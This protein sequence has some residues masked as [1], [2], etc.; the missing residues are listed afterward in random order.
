MTRTVGGFDW[1][2]GNRVKCRKHGVSTDEIESLFGGLLHVFPDA[3]HSSVETRFIGIGRSAGGRHV[4]VAF[5]LRR[6]RG[7]LLIRPISARYM[8]AKEVKHYEAQV[9]GIEDEPSGRELRSGF[10]PDDV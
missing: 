2:V 10:R 5:T 6:R 3:R 8:H 9:A 7:A 1:D 4:L